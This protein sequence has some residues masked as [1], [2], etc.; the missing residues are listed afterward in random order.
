MSAKAQDG[1]KGR[2][3]E[4]GPEEEGAEPSFFRMT[5]RNEMKEEVREGGKNDL[6]TVST[7]TLCPPN[8]RA[9]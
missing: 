5:G 3:S 8:T 9:N 6:H 2:L 7:Q 4:A 1:A